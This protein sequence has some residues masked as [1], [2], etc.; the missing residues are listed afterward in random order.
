MNTALIALALL[1]PLPRT[2]PDVSVTVRKGLE[3]LAKQQQADGSWSL[4]DGTAPTRVTAAA[5]L[6]LLMQGSTL[7]DGSYAPNLRKTVEWFEKKAAA[8]P[9][10]G[11]DR[12]SRGTITRDHAHAILFLVSA[13]DVDDDPER[14][15]RLKKIV[16]GAIAEA[17]KAQ[18]VRGGWTVALGAGNNTT[19]TTEN[20][21]DV[22]H[23]LFAARRSGFKVPQKVTD[24]GL[25]YLDKA[26]T[27]TG[28]H[29]RRAPRRAVAVG[30]V[31]RSRLSGAVPRDPRRRRV[32]RP[33]TVPRGA[34]VLLSGRKRAPPDRSG[35]ARCGS[36]EVVR[37]PRRALQRTQGRAGQGRRLGG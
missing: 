2:A 6:A 36:R 23:A 8:V 37:L 16:D 11:R 33:P 7:K 31:H 27:R 3:W 25:T 22:L 1:A 13:C 10:L 30:E 26:T 34:Y 17:L 18:T 24:A 14:A 5:G 19:D 35:R 29:G 4:S 9:S 15:A 28:A 20:T 12:D 32:H 21:A